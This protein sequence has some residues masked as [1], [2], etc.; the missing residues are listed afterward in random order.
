MVG[1][2]VQYTVG[3]ECTAIPTTWGLMYGGF[4]TLA[5]AHVLPLPTI[6]VWVFHTKPGVKVWG[7]SDN[8]EVDVD[9]STKP[10]ILH[11]RF[12]GLKSEVRGDDKGESLTSPLSGWKL[13]KSIDSGYASWYLNMLNTYVKTRLYTKSENSNISRNGDARL[14]IMKMQGWWH[15][16]R[17]HNV[18]MQGQSWSI[19]IYVRNYTQ[20]EYECKIHMEIIL[21]GRNRVGAWE[22]PSAGMGWGHA[23]VA[24]FT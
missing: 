15:E 13:L 21:W 22:C 4:L 3:S 9:L 24:W 8:K 1:W 6:K 5:S 7:L 2:D 20:L 16:G 11:S 10:E 14:A 18:E 19:A 17:L 23:S 12:G